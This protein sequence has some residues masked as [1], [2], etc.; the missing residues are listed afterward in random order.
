MCDTP[1]APT[2]YLA[3]LWTT[4][5][6]H[7]GLRVLRGQGK[8]VVDVL[9]AFLFV[10]GQRGSEVRCL[11]AASRVYVTVVLRVYQSSSPSSHVPFPTTI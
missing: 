9:F 2:D 7:R 3:P 8:S 6:R 1:A 10:P 5:Y 11:E 4:D